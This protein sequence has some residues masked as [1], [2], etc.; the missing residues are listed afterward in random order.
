MNVTDRYR[1]PWIGHATT[2]FWFII[3][4]PFA[5]LLFIALCPQFFQNNKDMPAASWV[6][7]I[8]L[9]DVAHVYS[10]LYRTYFDGHTYHKQKAL[11]TTIPFAAFVAGAV[12]YSMSNLWFWRILAYVAVYHFIRQQYG[13]MRIYS[14][15]EKEGRIYK[16]IDKFIIYYATIYP[17]VYWHLE[18]GR[19]FNWFVEGD[20]MHFRSSALLNVFTVVYGLMIII[21]IAK[22]TYAVYKTKVVNFPKLAIVIGTLLSWYFGIVYFNGDMAFTLLNVVS[23]GIPYMALV[24]LHGKKQHR[25]Q[26]KPNKL[27]KA[28]FSSY[29]ILLFLGIIFL[30]A[31]IEEG[32]WDSFVWKEHRSVFNLF[33]FPKNHVSETLLALLVPLLAVPQITHYIIDGFIWKIKD[34]GFKWNNEAAKK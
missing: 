17:I 11:L 27:F 6:I 8:L 4:P 29:G 33:Y 34:D 7:L 13:F 23:H 10:T 31:F 20:F 3:M 5:S 1:Q 21:F 14:R 19:N 24:W 15:K 25:L 9:V 32:I 12:V 2:E 26:P 16:T 30:L 28:V 18:P 22:E